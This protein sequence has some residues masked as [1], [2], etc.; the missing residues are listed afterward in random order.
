[1][2]RITLACI[3]FPALLLMV[4]TAEA[5]DKA[6]VDSRTFG[7]IEARHIGPARMSGRVSA[8]DAVKRDARIIYVGAASGGVWK[9]TNAGT[10]FKPVFDKHNQSIGAIAIDQLHPDTVWVGTGESWVRNSVSVGDGIYKTING[11]DSWEKTGLENTE[12]IGRIMLHPVNPDIVY[13]AVLGHLWNPNTDRGV[14]RT[15]DG[16]KTWEKVLYIDENTG[17]ADIVIDPEDPDI[18]YAGMWDFRRLPYTFRSGGKGSGLYKTTDGGDSWT[19]ITQ[20]LPEVNLGRIAVDISP[21]DPNIVYAVVEAAEKKTALFRS[22]DKGENWEEMNKTSAVSE[23]P[24]YFSLVVADPVDTNRVYKPGLYLNFSKDGGKTFSGGGMMSALGGGIHPDLHALWISPEDNNF[25]YLGTDG[26]VYL[27]HDQ[28]GTWRMMRNLPLSQFY[29][30]S[31]DMDKPYNVFGG[32]QDNGSWY[33]PSSGPGG[34][35]NGDWQ[36]VGGGDGFYVFRDPTDPNI[37][38][39]QYQGGNISRMYLNTRESK[40]IKPYTGEQDDKLRFNWNT[41]VVIGMKSGALYVGAQYLF[42]S[43]DRG[44]SWE[45]I[46]PDLTTNDPEKQKQKESGGVTLENT[47]AENHTTIITINESALDENII[48]VGTDDGNLQVTANGGAS[49]SNVTGNVPGLPE[50]TWCSYVFPDRFDKNTAYVTFDGHRH[51]D[52]KP[53]VYKTSDMGKTWAALANEDIPIY[54][55]VIVQD[56]VNPGLLFLGTEFGLYLSV[57]GGLGWS[58]FT[59]NLPNVPVMD[60]V[61]HPREHDL[62][63]ATHG[64]GIMVID[65]ITP[66]RHLSAEALEQEVAFLPS[67]P[68]ILRTVGSVQEY[69]GN[70]A[71][72]GQN[73]PEAALLTYH[74]KKRHIFGDMFIEVFDST[75]EKISTLP[76]GK[77]KGINRVP[78]NVRKK[79]PRV[80]RGSSLTYAGLF[81]PPLPAGEYTVRIVRDDE[82]TEGRFLLVDDPDSPHSPAD[83]ATQRKTLM[84]S[85]QMLE[86]LAYLDRQVTDMMEGAKKRMEGNVSRTLRKRLQT[87]HDAASDIRSKLVNTESLGMFSENVQL[88]EKISEI[89]GGVVNYLGRPTQSQVDNLDKLEEEMKDNAALIEKLMSADLPGINEALLKAGLEPMKIT[90]RE[91]FEKE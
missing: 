59:G 61:I 75:G 65:D 19:K 43:A 35:K 87:L 25:I 58:Q 34:I 2:I 10:T 81:G 64:R 89:Y 42:R 13:A 15:K 53:Y 29:H 79:A 16:G 36:N 3:F 57:D 18:L 40:S 83:R 88:R 9:S 90:T 6:D 51:G 12:R 45:K 56:L 50:N 62:V 91:E 48:W 22:T 5:Q 74:M 71:F 21:A 78:L 4:L 33:G 31:V 55:H 7:A 86:G 49:W 20:G 84:K 11:G 26:G 67:R 70:D 24:F 46:S 60:M 38:Y 47:S 85:Y 44:D 1:M 66:L 72:V 39:S 76:A 17:C 54:C 73:A 41:P 28:A 30:V 63:L 32:L 82:I 77:R 80:P 37:I 14:Y 8:L 68:Y 52:M 23:R 69:A 27:S